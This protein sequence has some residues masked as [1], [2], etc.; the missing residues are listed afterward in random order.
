MVINPTNDLVQEYL[1]AQGVAFGNNLLDPR[2]VPADGKFSLIIIV[3]ITTY[4]VYNGFEGE[5]NAADIY[6]MILDSAEN[7]AMMEHVQSFLLSALV[8]P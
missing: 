3:P 1:A 8:A 6:E 7:N 2:T 4:F 5:L